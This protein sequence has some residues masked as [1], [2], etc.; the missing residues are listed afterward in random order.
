MYFQ[1]KNYFKKH[2]AL[3]SQ[4]YHKQAYVVDVYSHEHVNADIAIGAMIS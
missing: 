1:V 4:I 2:F 3:Q